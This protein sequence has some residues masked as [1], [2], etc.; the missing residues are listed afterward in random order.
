MSRTI[1][2]EP[3]APDAELP[4]APPRTLTLQRL[5]AEKFARYSLLFIVVLTGV[6]FFNMVKAFFVPVILAAVFAGLF[7][8]FYEWLLKLAR[9]RRVISAF[10]C[11]LMLSLGVLLPAYGVA[12]LV[13]LEAVRLYQT[14]QTKGLRSFD[15]DFQSFAQRHPVLQ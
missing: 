6:V 11:C 10:V 1:A 3:P 8:P 13:A 2:T 12:N 5:R 7:H 15:A 4:P 9:G 14:V